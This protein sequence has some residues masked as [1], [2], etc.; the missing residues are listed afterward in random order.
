VVFLDPRANDELERI[1]REARVAHLRYYH[2]IFVEG[3]RI[4]HEESQSA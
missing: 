1:W 4:N 3:M 2:R